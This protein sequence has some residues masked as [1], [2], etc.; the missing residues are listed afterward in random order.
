MFNIKKTIY[1]SLSAVAALI[2]TSCN[3]TQSYSDLL[4]EQEHAVNWY[5]AQHK[6]CVEIPADGNFEVGENAPYYKM[7]EDGDVYMQV[8]NKGDEFPANATD[9]EK[10]K[11]QFNL[12]DKVYLRFM[13]MNIKYY[14]QH[15]QEIWEGNSEILDNAQG[16]LPII[17]GNTVL[18]STTEYGEG[19]Q[20]PMQYLHNNSEVNLIVK[21]TQGFSTDQST[22]TPYLYKIQYFKAI[23]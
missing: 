14:F 20:V 6:V 5:L 12:G 3:D 15:N 23:Y 16:S 4:N 10:E 22:C 18:Q 9:E 2:I 21:S 11:I 1:F 7:D 19:I 13:R 8:L 17:Y